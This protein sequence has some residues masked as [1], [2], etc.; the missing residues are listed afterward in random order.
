MRKKYL[1]FIFFVVLLLTGCGQKTVMDQ[2]SADGNFYYNNKD[3]G[4]NLVLPPDFLYYQT[5]R[6]DGGNFIDIEFFTPTS[7][8]AYP[9]EIQSYAKPIVVRVF[10]NKDLWNENGDKNGFQKLEK[11]NK[12]YA[13]KFWDK[14]PADWK[15]KWSEEMKKG[16]IDGFRAD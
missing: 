10:N 11:G 8:T 13:I 16:I 2:P 12:I 3:L 6:K 1:F 14:A 5:Q 4:F 15:D 7:D 9:Q